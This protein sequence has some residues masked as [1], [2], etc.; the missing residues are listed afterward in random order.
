ME[1]EIDISD[2]NQAELIATVLH[3]NTAPLGFGAPAKSRKYGPREQDARRGR[4]TSRRQPRPL[5]RRARLARVPRRLRVPA[6]EAPPD[7]L[8]VRG[9]GEAGAGE[10]RAE[11]ED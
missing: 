6:A 4:S 8:L 10:G 11:R 1:N 2:L 9:A 3:S 5:V 7:S